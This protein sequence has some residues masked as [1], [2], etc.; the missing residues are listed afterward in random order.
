MASRRLDIS[1][2]LCDDSQPA[3]SPLDVLV[4]AATEERKR[5]GGVDESRQSSPFS[6]GSKSLLPVVND[7]HVVRSPVSSPTLSRFAVDDIQRIHPSPQ[8]LYLQRSRIHHDN[9]LLPEQ[10]QHHRQ[11][12]REID[13]SSLQ[14]GHSRR[15]QE[16]EHHRRRVEEQQR[17][18]E[19]EFQRQQDLERAF[20][21]QELE[22]RRREED[23]LRAME[24][25]RQQREQ[26]RREVERLQQYQQQIL[27][28][29]HKQRW[30]A[31]RLRELEEIQQLER[32]REAERLREGERQQEAV[33]RQQQ[34][35]AERL[36]GV[37]RLQ[38]TERIQESKRRSSHSSQ[39]NGE[40]RYTPRF[41]ESLSNNSSPSSIPNLIPNRGPDPLQIRRSVTSNSPD[42]AK[43]SIA[44]SLHDDLRPVKKRRYS[45]SPSRPISDDQD[46]I[47]RERERMLVGELG[48]STIESPVAD[49]ST[50]SRRPF[51]GLNYAR[52]YVAVADLLADN[53]PGPLPTLLL[54]SPPPPSVIRDAHRIISPT[55]RR[56]PPGSQIGRAKAA[57]KSDEYLA[58]LKEQQTQLG[59]LP[60][61][62]PAHSSILPDIAKVKEEPRFSH[63]RSRHVSDEIRRTPTVDESRQK[64]AVIKEA[65]PPPLLPPPKIPPLTSRI[66]QQD[67]AHEWFLHQY[68]EDPS[69][70][71][72]RP[73]VSSM[74][75][76]SLPNTITHDP[77]SPS[78]SQKVLT[79]ITAAVALE[80]ELEGLISTPL[81]PSTPAVKI[82]KQEV[83][84]DDMDLALDLAMTELVETMENDDRKH[85]G[86]EEDVEAELL[87][88]VDDRPPPSGQSTIMA[89]TSWRTLTP[90]VSASASDSH[91]HGPAG[92]VKSTPPPQ[93]VHRSP[94][95]H[96]QL[97]P[98]T[99]S[100][101]TVAAIPSGNSVALQNSVRTMSD[102]DSMPPP[103]TT[104]KG[105]STKK[106]AED[107]DGVVPPEPTS[108]TR[109]ASKRKKEVT[110]KV[111]NGTVFSFFHY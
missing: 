98:L 10:Q 11:P 81:V 28:E 63:Q 85:V 88:L 43:A 32:V 9:L 102:R 93:S 7:H 105:G 34:L 109:T 42:S 18:Q 1:S 22:R 64:K 78:A 5:L 19:L 68:D 27:L 66:K 67:D 56:S 111:C 13:Y 25:E 45:E 40:L 75:S 39:D 86:M 97:P 106:K 91:A 87:S 50:A 36:R 99:G 89:G 71:P 21:S 80:Q 107:V 20:R 104:F 94:S 33:E 77:K 57:R 92:V 74:P 110:V 49:T 62:E 29:E 44:P 61:K 58:S 41:P 53:E 60:P 84:D 23:H 108:A 90:S 14:A 69:P 2:L 30:E 55:G 100:Q 3:F 16:S 6:Q 31:E 70:M 38:E 15:A 26:E 48:N 72:S 47:A 96:L 103:A 8:H 46:R 76:S 95:D 51:T 4:H 35:E 65:P 24:F 54:P 37:V 17:I 82:T 101:G 79:P 12:S 52:K 59:P 83:D 73:E